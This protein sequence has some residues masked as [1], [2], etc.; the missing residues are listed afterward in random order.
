MELLLG[1][2][3]VAVAI[4][5]VVWPL[6]RT[7]QSADERAPEAGGL[8]GITSRREIYREVLDLELDHRVGKLSDEDYRALSEASLARA[9]AL[10]AEEERQIEAADIRVEQEIA[11][12][13]QALRERVPAGPATET[14]ER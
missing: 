3:V 11:A 7:E 12:M 1:A 4:G 2:T 14:V 13:R 10:V 6:F 8:S 9:T 5:F